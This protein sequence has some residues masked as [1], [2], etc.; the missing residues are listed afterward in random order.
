[1][2]PTSKLSLTSIAVLAASLLVAP[3]AA[4]APA[5]EGSDVTLLGQW[6]YSYFSNANYSGRIIVDARGGANLT[7]SWVSGVVAPGS[8]REVGHVVVDVPTVEFVFT[9]AKTGDGKNYNLD[10]FRC[11]LQSSNAL[12]CYNQD[13]AGSTS[14][15]FMLSRIAA[16]R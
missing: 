12:D 11:T 1:M 10:H 5:L 14:A 16:P 6:Q 13:V 2:Q 4:P 3:Q 15:M 8:V 9:T 7:A